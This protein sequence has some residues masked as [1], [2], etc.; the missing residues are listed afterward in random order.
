MPGA[1][2]SPQFLPNPNC[3]PV[4]WR[5]RAWLFLPRPPDHSQASLRSK[6]GLPAR[7]L[8]LGTGEE[9]GAEPSHPRLDSVKVLAPHSPPWALEPALVPEQSGLAE[10][11]RLQILTL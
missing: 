10:S 6:S 8:G 5:Q 11:I 2:A 7:S 3:I 4:S 9:L 1:A